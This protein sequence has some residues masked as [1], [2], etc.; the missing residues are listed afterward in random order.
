MQGSNSGGS[1][2]EPPQLGPPFLIRDPDPHRG[3]RRG[4]GM[5]STMGP[6]SSSYDVDGSQREADHDAPSGGPQEPRD[7]T[8]L[9]PSLGVGGGAAPSAGG[10][11]APPGCSVEMEITSLTFPT[12]S[13][14]VMS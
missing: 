7:A 10:A 2:A 13:V 3:E 5:A 11:L 14:N 6:P 8:T 4:P 1:R 9:P 12:A